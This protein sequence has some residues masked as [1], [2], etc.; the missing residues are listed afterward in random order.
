MR[1]ILELKVPEVAWADLAH[2]NAEL[3]AALRGLGPRASIG[4][5]LARVVCFAFRGLTGRR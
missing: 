5:C 3:F 2:P 1:L 4:L